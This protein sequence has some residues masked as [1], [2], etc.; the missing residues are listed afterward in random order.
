MTKKKPI[1]SW[2]NKKA[3]TILA[4]DA[5]ERKEIEDTLADDPKKLIGRTV[6]ISLRDLSGDRSKQ[7]LK[8]VFEIVETQGGKAFTR[9][10]RFST[11]P[12]YLKSKIRKGMSKLDIQR[13]LALKDD[14]AQL[15]MMVLTRG[16]VQEHQRRDLTRAVDATLNAAQKKLKAEELIQQSLFGKLGTEIYQKLKKIHPIHR[17]EVFEVELT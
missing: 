12:G 11:S 1:A 6:E 8:L 4:P 2:K 5:F 3:Y 7:H 15:K 17:V 10:K 16:R 13:E 9:A 14:K